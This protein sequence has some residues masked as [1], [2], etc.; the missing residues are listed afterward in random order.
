MEKKHAGHLQLFK[1]LT[2]RTTIAAPKLVVPVSQGWPS[3][4]ERY[5]K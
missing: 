5:F 3:K 2:G 4:I 1:A